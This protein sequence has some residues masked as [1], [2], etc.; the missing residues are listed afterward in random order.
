MN[1]NQLCEIEGER[2]RWQ[3]FTYPFVV[4]SFCALF[5]PYCM[6]VFTLM[7]GNFDLSKWISDLLTTFAVCLGLSI[8]FFFL[9][10]LNRCF[11][12]KIVCVLNEHGLHHRD[13]VIHW[14]EI[15][16]IEYEIEVPGRS[17]K[18]ERRFCHAIIYTKE[19]KIVL[20][21][22]PLFL[23][24]KVKKYRPNIDAY[25]S[26]NSK[27]MIAMSIILVVVLVPMIPLLHNT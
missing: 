19:D 10:V 20:V 13:G 8:P 17:P 23:L 24:S 27:W 15:M 9:A 16:K 5:A 4:F 18:M 3:Y 11:F 2:I 7:A 26:K 25:V 14:D 6:L 1:K 12:G 21:H 22:A